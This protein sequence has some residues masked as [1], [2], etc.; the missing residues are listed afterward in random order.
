VTVRDALRMISEERT[1]HQ[2]MCR[3]ADYTDEQRR[4]QY[5][6]IIEIENLEIVPEQAAGIRQLLKEDQSK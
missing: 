1:L 2:W 4:A 6:K 5:A 3:C